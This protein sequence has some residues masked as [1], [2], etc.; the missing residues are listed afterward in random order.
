M[1]N[2]NRQAENQRKYNL[3]QA[4][5]TRYSPWTGQKG[6]L[7]M[8]DTGSPLEAGVGGAVQ[9]LGLTQSLGG[10]LGFGG[11]AQSMAP[12]SQGLSL[13]GQEMANELGERYNMSLPNI[14]QTQP[15]LQNMGLSLAQNRPRTPYG[16]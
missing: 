1:T 3:A 15:K 7:S 13:G 2:Q 11:A 14:Y 16:Y 12:Q 5:M 6:Q 10:D 4:E 9:G 8:S